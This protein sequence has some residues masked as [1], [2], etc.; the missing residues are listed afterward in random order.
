M[1]EVFSVAIELFGSMSLHGSLCRDTV[2]RLHAVDG[3][4]QG[5]SWSRQSCFIL[6]FFRNRGPHGF[7]TVCCFFS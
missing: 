2:Y 6:F 7:T 3:L 4:R 5:F 1:T